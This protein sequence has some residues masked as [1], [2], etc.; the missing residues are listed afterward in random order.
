MHRLRTAPLAFILA[1]CGQPSESVPSRQA[2]AANPSAAAPAAPAAKPFVFDQKDELI[3]FHYAW[4]AEAAAVPE[5]VSR[6][7]ADMEKS[8]AD[9][10]AGAKEDKAFRDKDGIEFHGFQSSTDYKTAGQSSRLLSLTSDFGA[11]TGGAHGNYGTAGLL[12][13]R[14]AAREI[15]VADLFAAPANRDR[16]LTQRWCEALNKEREKKRGEPVSGNDMFDECPSLD[17]I[18][19]VPADKDGNG[20]FERLVLT[21]SPYVAGPYAEGDYEVDLPV[22]PDLVSALKAEYRESFDVDH[23]Q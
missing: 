5:L 6:F 2:S 21:A 18:A 1:A 14:Q 23:P 4:S 20:R 17:D 9:L 19:V 16:L 15:Q 11:Y 12:W 8:K 3:E 22:T 7:T 13:D 10:I